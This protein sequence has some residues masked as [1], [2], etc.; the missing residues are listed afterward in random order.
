MPNSGITKYRTMT[1]ENPSSK[2]EEDKETE[3]LKKK[4]ENLQ[5][6]LDMTRRTIDH[7]KK[8]ML[9]TKDTFGKYEMM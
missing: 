2:P 5:K 7:D 6:L 8:F 3:E 9:N 4:V 1:P